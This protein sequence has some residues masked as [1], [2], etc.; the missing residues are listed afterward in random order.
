M[1]EIYNNLLDLA[2]AGEFDIIIH[3]CNCFHTMNSGIAKQIRERYP[4]VYEADKIFSKYGDASK[5]GTITYKDLGDFVVVNC[6]T[7]FRYGYDGERY[8]EYGAVRS[9][10]KELK[11]LYEKVKK[12]KVIEKIRIGIPLIGCGKAGGDW[13][14]VKKIVN[15]ELKEYDVTIVRFL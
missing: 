7:Q 4:D 11:S 13:E 15:D 1:K 12:N 8:V 9:C 5:L 2:E 3:G 14:I 6:Y 10:L